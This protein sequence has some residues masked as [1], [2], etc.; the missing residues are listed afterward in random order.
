M[1]AGGVA[2]EVTEAEREM[3]ERGEEQQEGEQAPAAGG[4]WLSGWW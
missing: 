2:A 3:A 1:K 4:G